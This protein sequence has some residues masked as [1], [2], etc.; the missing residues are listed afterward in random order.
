MTLPL[1]L[2]GPDLLTEININHGQHRNYKISSYN[3]NILYRAL[4]TTRKFYE[5]DLLMAIQ[6]LNLRGVYIDVG[7]S[8]GNHSLFFAGACMSTKVYSF[9]PFEKNYKLLERNIKNNAFV[10][11]I[12]PQMIAISDTTEELGLDPGPSINPANTK[13]VEGGYGIPASTIDIIFK[14]INMISLI[15]IDVEGHEP[16]VLN[17]ALNTLKKYKPVLAIESHTKDEED[18]VMD[19]LKPFGY[20]KSRKY[21]ATPTYIYT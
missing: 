13:V 17:G 2:N 21:C 11:K 9:E 5:I 8:I 4:Y 19:L 1:D 15:K 6:A 14:D 16:Q 7:A 12:I 20:N 18:I 3:N 10:N